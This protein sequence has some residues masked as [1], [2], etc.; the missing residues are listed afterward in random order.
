MTELEL[1]NAGELHHFWDDEINQLAARAQ[2]LVDKYNSTP[3]NDD[4]TKAKIIKE[5]LGKIG[6][7][8][9]VNQPFHCDYGKFIEIGGGSFLNYDCIILTLAKLKLVTMFLSALVPV[10]IVHHIQ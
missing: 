4:E 3:A 2:E 7:Y 6:D 5:L 9:C 1:M 10:F 8:S